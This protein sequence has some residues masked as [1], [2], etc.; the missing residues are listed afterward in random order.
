MLINYG[1]N[2]MFTIFLISGALVVQSRFNSVIIFG[3]CIGVH[4]S[5][6]IEVGGELC[7]EY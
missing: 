2:Q 7:K 5:W 3:G 4:F 6:Y 1:Y